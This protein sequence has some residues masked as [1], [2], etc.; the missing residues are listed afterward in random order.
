MTS[1][2]NRTTYGTNL[3]HDSVNNGLN[4][5]SLPTL[6]TKDTRILLT[7]SSIK[8][9]RPNGRRLLMTRTL[10][11]FGRITSVLRHTY[12]GKIRPH[13]TTL[14]Y[15][16][17]IRPGT[18]T[19]MI[20]TRTT[21]NMRQRQINGNNGLHHQSG[22]FFPRS[23]NSTYHVRQTFNSTLDDDYRPKDMMR[24]TDNILRNSGNVIYTLLLRLPN[25]NTSNNF[26]NRNN[27][28]RLY[29]TTTN[30]N[31]TIRQLFLLQLQLEHYLQDNNTT[32]HHEKDNYFNTKDTFNFR[33]PVLSR[34]VPYINNPV[35]R[36]K[37]NGPY[38][39]RRYHRRRGGTS[40]TLCTHFPTMGTTIVVL[41][42]LAFVL[43]RNVLSSLSTLRSG[44]VSNGTVSYRHRRTS[45]RRH[46]KRTTRYFKSNFTTRTIAHFNS[47]RRHRR[48]TGTTTGTGT[49]TLTGNG[50]LNT[51][52]RRHTRR[53]TIRHNR[54]RST[55]RLNTTKRTTRRPR[56]RVLYRT[57]R[58]S[59]NSVRRQTRLNT[60][61]RQNSR[62]TNGRDRKYCRRLHSTRRRTRRHTT[63]TII[64]R[65]LRRTKRTR[66]ANGSDIL[67]GGDRRYV[68]RGCY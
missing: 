2:R 26:V 48:V 14:N 33:I 40:T 47:R 64:P 24:H 41:S 52:R 50:T 37:Y 16:S 62:S 51:L 61:V 34:N 11:L 30:S 28:I 42:L 35:R 10:R 65:R 38:N 13:L 68:T 1:P 32:Y 3:P 8:R 63:N 18:I 5:T 56:R 15:T 57:R 49:G 23:N 60:I 29:P 45:V 46:S 22:T 31:L 9:L 36:V 44:K 6:T 27:R 59:T 53:T 54:Q 17:I 12:N 58:N 19:I 66:Y 43:D 7:N 4:N 21:I 39:Y 55:R 67:Y 25:D 20:R